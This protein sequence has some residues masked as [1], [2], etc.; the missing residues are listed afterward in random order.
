[1]LVTLILDIS[2]G[3]RVKMCA[4]FIKHQWVVN[5]LYHNCMPYEWRSVLSSAC[6]LLHGH[7]VL[8]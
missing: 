5:T 7:Q 4:G 3:R 1:M 2:K 8:Q 6:C